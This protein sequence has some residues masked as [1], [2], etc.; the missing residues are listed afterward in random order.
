[1]TEARK[2]ELR[3]E[4]AYIRQA[5]SDPAQMSRARLFEIVDELLGTPDNEFSEQQQAAI[6]SLLY[7]RMQ[8]AF[9]GG[10][11][12]GLAGYTISSRDLFGEWYKGWR[13]E[14]D[15]QMAQQRAMVE[16]RKVAA[17]PVGP[18]AGE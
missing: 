6:T 13:A 3:S 14:Q 15:A 4:I 12:Y 7:R 11:G 2:A 1:M 8:E 17:G 5:G 10:Q 18:T 9:L 16:Y